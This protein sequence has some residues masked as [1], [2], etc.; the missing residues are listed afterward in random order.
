[1]TAGLLPCNAQ[2][3]ERAL[4]D[5]AGTAIE[6]V[7]VERVRT[8]ADPGT[9]PAPLLPWLAWALSVDEWDGAW[10]EAVQRAVIAASVAVHRHKGTVGSV[11]AA[12]AAAGWP[13]ALI[14]EGAA[15]VHYD[16]T[17]Q[18]DGTQIYG[19]DPSDWA[20]YR[21]EVDAPI[22]IAQGALIRRVAEAV[23]P[24][25]CHLIEVRFGSSLK[26][27]GAVRYDGQYRHG[28]T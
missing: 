1:M 12:I 18:H 16:G 8:L 5:V 19:G 9:C 2:P 13:H 25:R 24:V 23:H 20:V 7:D 27:N 6:A 3:L 4:E 17:Y 21:V 10:P 11:R 26:Y 22:T 28:A 15:D 14:V